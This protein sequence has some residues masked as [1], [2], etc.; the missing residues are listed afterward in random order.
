M[1]FLLLSSDKRNIAI[2]TR[3]FSALMRENVSVLHCSKT[4]IP[5]FIFLNTQDNLQSR[6]HIVACVDKH[7][8]GVA[9]ML[10][11]QDVN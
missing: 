8:W 7:R 11:Y 3:Q 5:E 2:Q 10:A 9:C 1:P 4:M 6:H